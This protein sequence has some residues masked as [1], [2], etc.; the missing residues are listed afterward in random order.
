MRPRRSWS[1]LALC[2]L[3]AA[4]GCASKKS[5]EGGAS[6]GGAGGLFRLGLPF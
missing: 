3:L 1:M 5:V 4:S 6:D 2:L